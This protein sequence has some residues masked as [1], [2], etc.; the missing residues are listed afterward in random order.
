MVHHLL[1]AVLSVHDLLPVW[2]NWVKSEADSER[3]I[4]GKKIYLVN[5]MS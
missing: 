3:A 5:A 4:S 1:A 2:P